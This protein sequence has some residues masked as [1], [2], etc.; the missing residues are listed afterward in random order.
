MTDFIHK[1]KDLTPEKRQLLFRR[2]RQAGHQVNAFPLSFAQRRL[3]F[4]DQ[5]EPDSPVYNVPVVLR[6]RGFLQPD[7]LEQSLHAI[8]ERHAILRARLLPAGEEPLQVIMP[9]QQISLV[10]KDFAADSASWREAQAQAYLRAEARRPFDVAN[11][12]L[13]RLSLLRLAEEEHILF[14]NL[15]HC[16][17]DS[18]AIVALLEELKSAYRAFAAG[19]AC[20]LPELPIQYTDFVLWQREQLQPQRLGPALAYWKHQLYAPLPVLELPSDHPRP[21]AP[22]SQGATHT[23]TFSPQLREDLEQ[24]SSYTGV[25]LF[26][27]APSSV[28][29]RAVSLYR[30]NRSDCGLSD[31]GPKSSRNQRADRLLSQHACPA[32]RSVRESDLP[33][34]LIPGAQNLSRCLC[35]PAAAL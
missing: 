27:D 5:L 9:E 32:D 10:M 24:F 28:S 17:A 6:L 7:V 31:I 33:R 13:V 14:V 23:F 8:V 15:H 20:P 2:L 12:P 16:I 19:Q 18:G 1:I 26:M 22:S 30:T 21:A 35:P 29:N 25:T 3:W 34:T 11:E 4:L